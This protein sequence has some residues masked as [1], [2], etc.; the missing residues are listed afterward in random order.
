MRKRLI[1]SQQHPDEQWLEV[2]QMATVEVSSE[3]PECPIEHALLP[4]GK[5]G[6]RAAG[7]GP[8]TIR[9]LFDQPQRVRRI[10]LVFTESA[11]PRTQ[12]FLLRWSGD[13]QQSFQEIVRQQ[14]NFHPEGSTRESEDYEVNLHAVTALELRIKPDIGGANATASL[15]QWLVA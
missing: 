8:Q 9:M 7:P 11:A 10:R 12:E 13:R 1:S 5:A 14:W 6:W 2:E 4:G 15:T 3:D